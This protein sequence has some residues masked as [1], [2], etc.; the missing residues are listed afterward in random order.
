M[1]Q[2]RQEGV[3]G[4]VADGEWA[5]DRAGWAVSASVQAGTAYAR[6]VVKKLSTSAAR[7]ATRSNARAVVPRWKE[8][9]DLADFIVVSPLRSTT[10][11]A[12]SRA[13]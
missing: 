2:D 1:E 9:I 7:P 12:G 13:C 11:A 6:A 4:L 3:L 8:A 10:P 5:K